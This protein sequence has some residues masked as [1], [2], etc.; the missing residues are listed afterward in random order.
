MDRNMCIRIYI[1]SL[2]VIVFCGV[3]KGGESNKVFFINLCCLYFFN[4][5]NVLICDFF[6]KFI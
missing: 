5:E 3:R 4:K 6:I 2:I 1:K